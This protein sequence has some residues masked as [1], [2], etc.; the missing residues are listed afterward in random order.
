MIQHVEVAVVQLDGKQIT[1]VH[2][3]S[4]SLIGVEKRKYLKHDLPDCEH[5]KFGLGL[6]LLQEM[7]LPL[8]LGQNNLHDSWCNL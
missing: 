5:W 2:R 1:Q 4:L 3:V 6:R 8:E 7:D